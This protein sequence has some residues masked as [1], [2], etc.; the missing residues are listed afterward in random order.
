MLGSGG[1]HC[2]QRGLIPFFAVFDSGQFV[3]AALLA[4]GVFSLC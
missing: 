3:A 2:F 4:A 1:V